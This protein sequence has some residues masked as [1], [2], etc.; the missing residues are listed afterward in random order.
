M[1]CDIESIP[2]ISKVVLKDAA[3]DNILKFTLNGVSGLHR[4]EVFGFLLGEIKDSVATI[5]R[6]LV[7]HGG[8]SSQKKIFF[9]ETRLINRAKEIEALTGL[10]YLGLFHSH[11][12]LSGRTLAVF[13]YV[14]RYNM[15]HDSNSIVEVLVAIFEKKEG[16][17]GVSLKNRII[18]HQGRVT[19]LLSTYVKKVGQSKKKYIA[20]GRLEPS[21]S[22]QN[23]N[24]QESLQVH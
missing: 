19:F 24:I 10:D 8:K 13:S 5:H 3:L 11:I 21:F 14:D 22:I 12:P 18:V 23:R 16:L 9:V 20:L 17:K 15:Y 6:S 7:Y 1:F 2:P 4:R